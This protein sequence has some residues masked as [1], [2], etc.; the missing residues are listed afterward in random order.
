[1]LPRRTPEVVESEPETDTYR[2][3]YEYPSHPPSIAVSL[4][5][6]EATDS[7][8]SDFDPL[9]DEAS[10]DPDVLDALFRPPANGTYREVRVTFT[11]HDYQITVKG[12]GRIIIEA[13][14]TQ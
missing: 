12:H 13:P 5:L 9:Y 14:A 11:Y 6:I 7:S 3:T 1:M 10:V 2:A 4:G 8:V